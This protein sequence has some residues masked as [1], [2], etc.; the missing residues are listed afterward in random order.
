MLLLSIDV[1]ILP[2]RYAYREEEGPGLL[3][4]PTPS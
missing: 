3:E 1:N 4:T 2:A